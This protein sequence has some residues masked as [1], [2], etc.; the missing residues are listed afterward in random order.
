MKLRTEKNKEN[1]SFL[2][3]Q[4]QNRFSDGSVWKLL[5]TSNPSN[6]TCGFCFNQRF[7]DF[8]VYSVVFIYS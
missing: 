5:G 6:C 3:R 2:Q 4:R 7:L 1:K 8:I